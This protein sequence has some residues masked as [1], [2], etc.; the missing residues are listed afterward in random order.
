MMDDV[1]IRRQNDFVTLLVILVS[2]QKEL[3]V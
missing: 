3:V 2:G 1:T